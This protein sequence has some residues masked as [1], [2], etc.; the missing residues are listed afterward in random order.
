LSIVGDILQIVNDFQFTLWR[1]IHFD[2]ADR[3]PLSMILSTV[4]DSLY[5]H[6]RRR[7]TIHEF[8]RLRSGGAPLLGG[9]SACGMMEKRSQ[10]VQPV[11]DKL[12]DGRPSPTMTK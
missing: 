2:L 12:V 3:R 11:A 6:G 4:D 8:D 10:N 7:P 9:P 5:R 1:S